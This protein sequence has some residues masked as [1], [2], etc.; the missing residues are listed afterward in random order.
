M[1]ITSKGRLEEI[2][3]ISSNIFRI[4]GKSMQKLQIAKRNIPERLESFLMSY[5]TLKNLLLKQNKISYFD[6]LFLKDYLQK[7]LSFKHKNTK[8][9]AEKL[10][11]ELIS[12]HDKNKEIFVLEKNINSDKNIKSLFKIIEYQTNKLDQYKLKESVVNARKK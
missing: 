3:N 5:E 9:I 12:F 10:I 1:K 7:F 2:D 4:K 8:R 6:F 11:C